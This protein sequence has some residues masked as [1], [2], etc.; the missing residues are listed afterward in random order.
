[1]TDLCLIAVFCAPGTRNLPL[2]PVDRPLQRYAL[3][4]NLMSAQ[5]RVEGI[6]L[7][8]QGSSYLFINSATC[9]ARV[10]LQAANSLSHQ[11]II[12][13]HLGGRLTAI[14]ESPRRM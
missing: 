4:Y 9:F 11:R 3:G 13:S 6:E 10:T 14:R 7:V 1:D 8:A 12:I 5:R 2:D